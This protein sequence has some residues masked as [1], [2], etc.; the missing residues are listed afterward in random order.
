LITYFELYLS[1]SPSIIYT[2]NVI[3]LLKLIKVK[4][5]IILH[6]FCISKLLYNVYV[7]Y[8]LNSLD[9]FKIAPKYTHIL[10]YDFTNDQHYMQIIFYAKMYNIKCILI[11]TYDEARSNSSY[12]S[13]SLWVDTNKIV[14]KNLNDYYYYIYVKR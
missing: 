11:K 1:N 13:Y 3:T 7:S 6:N 4:N 8:S 12:N 5:K 14:F 2:N 10:K 9:L